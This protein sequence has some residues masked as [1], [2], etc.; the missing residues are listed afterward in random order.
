MAP[1]VAMLNTATDAAAERRRPT[2]R[3]T[4][5]AL[6][7]NVHFEHKCDDGDDLG[8]VKAHVV[9]SDSG[10]VWNSK[11]SDVSYVDQRFTNKKFTDAGTT[12][13]PTSFSDACSCKR[14]A[15][16]CKCPAFVDMYKFGMRSQ[17]VI[18]GQ[19]TRTDPFY[20]LSAIAE[21]FVFI[22]ISSSLVAVVAFYLI[23]SKSR[24]YNT[25][26][27]E[28]VNIDIVNARLA[29]QTAIAALSFRGLDKNGDGVISA[30]EFTQLFLQSNP[31]LTHDQAA[32]MASHILKVADTNMAG[33]ISFSEFVKCISDD[34]K[35]LDLMYSNVARPKF[36]EGGAGAQKRLDPP[37]H[38]WEER[39]TAEGIKYYANH[40]TRVTTWYDPRQAHPAQGFAQ[41]GVQGQFVVVQQNNAQVVP[42]SVVV[43]QGGAPGAQV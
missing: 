30:E 17:F 1:A 18:T 7:I 11:G 8:K 34:P 4:G 2:Y 35:S 9:V 41:A 22:M 12:G 28:E 36:E 19:S 29:A 24:F 38:M 31:K 14:N 10:I 6:Q 21:A 32:A 27:T 43:Q 39:V 33:N 3:Q 13:T 42:Q 16:D 37:F 40:E 26:R 23:P 15:P 25:R 20:V 5:L